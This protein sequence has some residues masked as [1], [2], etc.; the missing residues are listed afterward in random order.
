MPS[1]LLDSHIVPEFLHRPIYDEDHEAIYFDSTRKGIRRRGFWEE[2]LCREC[3]ER[4]GKLESYF[5]DLWFKQGVRPELVIRGNRPLRVAGL[6][7]TRFKLFHLS[8]LWRASIATLRPFQEIRLGIHEERLRSMLLTGVAGPA[9]LYPLWGVAV[10][11]EDGSY[12][13][14][15][16]QLP[17]REACR[18]PLLLGI[19]RRRLLALQN[20]EPHLWV[21]DSGDLD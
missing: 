13:D 8:I 15:M 19:V 16:L 7:Y 17:G 2:L 18:P 21:D 6:D 10:R 1:H 5:A 9:E 14:D 20:L 11:D 12:K 3:E 4:I